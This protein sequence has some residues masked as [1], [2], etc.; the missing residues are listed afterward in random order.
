MKIKSLIENIVLKLHRVKKMKESLHKICSEETNEEEN[1]TTNI[2][3]QTD[4]LQGKIKF[5][6]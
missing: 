5:Q 3:L 2:N 4:L 6:I 1:E